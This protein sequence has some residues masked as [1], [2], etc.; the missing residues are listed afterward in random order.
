M[1]AK[2]KK[3]PTRLQ[4]TRKLQE[5][6]RINWWVIYLIVFGLLFFLPY[7]TSTPS[8]EITWQ[9][10]EQNLLNTKKVEKLAVI[11]NERVEV[12]L[13][14]VTA[15]EPSFKDISKLKDDSK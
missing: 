4:P 7:F 8:Q 5:R 10:F 14:S 1:N 3:K 11:N 12:Y 15:K 13:K 2:P 9:Y 6:F